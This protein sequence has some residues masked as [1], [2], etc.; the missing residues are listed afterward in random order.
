MKNAVKLLLIRILSRVLPLGREF[1]PKHLSIRISGIYMI[2]GGAWILLSDRA[3]E[4]VSQDP[5]VITLV[6]MLKGWVYVFVTGAVLY[7]VIYTA[8]AH[9]LNAKQELVKA[10]GELAATNIEVET[11]NLEL[12]A[13]Q[14][15]L[16]KQYNQLLQS[17]QKLEEY[18]AEIHYLA[19]HDPL[20]GLPNRLAFYE[21]MSKLFSDGSPHSGALLFLDLDNFKYINDTMGHAFGDQLIR[22]VSE[23]LRNCVKDS[24]ASFY[25][26]GGDEFVISIIN[27][28]GTNDIENFAK[29]ILESFG[30]SLKV[31]SVLLHVTVSIGGTFYN[32][33]RADID[34]L[35]RQADIALYKAKAAGK[36][37]FVIYDKAMK[38]EVI[39]RARVEKHLRDALSNNEFKIFY[40]PQLDLNS[41]RVSGFEALMRWENPKLG[42]VPPSRFI[43][44]AEDTHLIVSIG[45]WVLRNA[46]IFIKNLHNRGYHD[47][48][49][50]VNVSMLQLIQNNFV[51]IV[52]SALDDASLDSKYL[53]L[54]ITESIMMESYNEIN[55]KLELLREKGVRIALDDFGKGYSSLTYLKQLPISTLKIDK[56][57]IETIFL[58]EKNKTLTG[59][60]VLLGKNIGL[61]VVAEGVETKEQFDFL[62]RH[63]CNK[64][65]GFIFSEPI[66][67]E[68]VLTKL[69]DGLSV[70]LIH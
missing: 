42:V 19:Y 45:E 44:V 56:T 66:S 30:T 32:T 38:E 70:E 13:S 26:F 22:R 68:A 25:K 9:I 20:T 62:V 14:E 51:D 8:L 18:Q 31:R 63:G 64:I 4:F 61:S 53:E 23:R 54:E 48:C 49:I 3:L 43:R 10:Y 2:F 57:F 34:Q 37:R 15:E 59:Q 29:P 35:L 5:G 41:G 47:L 46:C 16:T 7:I 11:V 24:S 12:I 67:E 21:D 55:L 58:E 36:N 52:V 40:Q 33:Q 69:K 60:I 17:Q 1:D 28:R 27:A 39:E 50:S 6:S 65:Q